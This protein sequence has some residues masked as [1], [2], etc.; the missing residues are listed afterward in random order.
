VT[1]AD[2]EIT[3]LHIGLKG[4]MNAL[5]L[6]DLAQKTRRGLRGRIEIGRS[7]GGLCYGYDVVRDRRSGQIG[8]AGHRQINTEEANVV[9]RIFHSFA[10]GRSPRRI[11]SELNS[12]GIPAPGGAGW[13]TSTVNGNRARGTGILNNELYIGRLVWN[14]LKY[15]KDPIT[16]KRASRLNPEA[17]WVIH[18]VPALRIVDQDLWERVKLRQS[19]VSRETRPDRAE[20]PFW[21]K[22]RPR[23]LLSGV[24]RCGSCGGAYTKVNASPIWLR[25]C[26]Q[27]RELQQPHE[28][29]TRAYRNDRAERA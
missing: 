10:I 25:Y 1:L 6:K 17:D 28:Y 29:S 5:F 11:A 9:R 15:S 4:T 18:E 8:E 16:G 24:L 20:R 27:Q 2:G 14:R 22:T 7:G 3:E 12:E 23:Y 21:A 26:P 19:E 13:G